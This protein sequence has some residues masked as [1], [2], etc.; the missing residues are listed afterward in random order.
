[1]KSRPAWVNTQ[2]FPFESKWFSYD[3]AQMHYIDEGSGDV[4]LFVHGVPEWSFGYREVVRELRTSF[5]CVVVDHLGFGLS[6]KPAGADYSVAAHA[7]RFEKFVH[8]LGVRNVT[9]VASDFGGG[10]GL[11]YAVQQPVNIRALL[12]FN[13]W[14]WSLKHEPQ[15]GLAGK[16]MKTW[17]MKFLY[18]Q[19]NFSVNVIMPKAYGD[20]KKLTKELHAHYQEVF[21]DAASRAPLYKIGRE[22]ADASEWWQAVWQKLDVLQHKPV[23]LFWGMKDTF[24]PPALLQ[25][26]TQRFPAA[27]VTRVTDAGH[28]VQEERPDVIVKGIRELMALQTAAS[29]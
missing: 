14:C 11:G 15:M 27:E 18:T 19:F 5:R 1:M 26:W 28:F 4:L 12:L 7:A 22:L 17:L 3:G 25:K 20:R 16:M 23:R 9:I 24:V 8:H 2:M 21:P 13:T 6:D 29:S 10:I